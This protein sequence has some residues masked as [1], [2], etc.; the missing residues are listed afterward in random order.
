MPCIGFGLK[1]LESL[2]KKWGLT[3]VPLGQAEPSFDTKPVLLNALHTHQ[4]CQVGG[5]AAHEFPV[6]AHSCHPVVC[7]FVQV[8]SHVI[9][10]VVSVEDKQSYYKDVT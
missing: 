4:V 9:L 1:C 6:F 7:S 2:P 3:P 5:F 10:Q 8:Q